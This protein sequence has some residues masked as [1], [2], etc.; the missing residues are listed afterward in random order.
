MRLPA[1]LASALAFTLVAAHAQAADPAAAQALFEQGK[2]LVATQRYALACPKFEESQRLDP[3]IGTLFNY[4]D[5]EE[6]LGKTATAWA[7]FLEVAS[8]AR[9]QG[10]SARESAARARASAVAPKVAKL[11]IDPGAAGT[12]PALEVVRDGTPIGRAQWATAVPV[13]PGPHT[14]EAHAPGKLAWTTRVNLAEG[15][16]EVVAVPFLHDAPSPPVA[17]AVPSP[18]APVSTT[19]TTSGEAEVETSNRGHGQRVAGIALG[20]A[21]IVALGVGGGFGIDSIVRHDQA[22]SHCAA[23]GCDATG[24]S[25]RNEAR[26]AGD[27][28]TIALAGGGALLLVGILTYATA[29]RSAPIGMA[30]REA[31]I[32]FDVGP[33]SAMVRGVW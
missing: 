30:K 6:H 17:A 26:T 15:V 4:A 3:G 24:V 25:M 23:N 21:G 8:E 19:R 5:C 13:D 29:P 11:T 16:G 22:R 12:T 20:A 1:S 27:A 10:E 7:A 33:G 2:Q 28:S 9:T 14:I 18:S 31:P 32:T